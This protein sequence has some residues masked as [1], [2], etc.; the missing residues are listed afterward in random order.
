MNLMSLMYVFVC[1]KEICC[2]AHTTV[3]QVVCFCDRERERERI[4]VYSMWVGVYIYIY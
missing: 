1:V 2:T 3:G 4:D